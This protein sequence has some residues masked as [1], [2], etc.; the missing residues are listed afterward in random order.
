MKSFHF[1]VG[2]SNDG[3]IGMCARVQAETP[4]QALELLKAYLPEEVEVDGNTPG[5]EYVR[6]YIN[7]AN[8][9]VKDVTETEADDDIEDNSY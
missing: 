1:D 8:I 2:N 6:V 9:T 5:V 3:P 7:D 4:E